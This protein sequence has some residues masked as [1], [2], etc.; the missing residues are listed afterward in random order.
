M[1]LLLLKKPLE[2]ILDRRTCSKLYTTAAPSG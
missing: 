2:K 1:S